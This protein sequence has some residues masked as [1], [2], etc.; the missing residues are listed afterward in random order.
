MAIPNLKPVPGPFIAPPEP[1][2][3]ELAFVDFAA[4]APVDPF[5]TVPDWTEGRQA[6]AQ[7]KIADNVWIAKTANGLHSIWANIAALDLGGESR[8]YCAIEDMQCPVGGVNAAPIALMMSGVYDN[9]FFWG[10]DNDTGG[11]IL[12]Y[13][14]T[15]N[16]D[17]LAVHAYRDVTFQPPYASNNFGNPL[18]G[19]GGTLGRVEMR[20]TIG[21]LDNTIQV[22]VDGLQL[23][24]DWVDGHVD[25]V[26]NLR[27]CGASLKADAAVAS[28]MVRLSSGIFTV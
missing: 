14:L 26:Q 5:S 13:L 25:R 6:G 9:G 27:T 1:P 28:S 18:G 10:S 21:A 3:T 2:E 7:S 15:L 24:G 8:V 11:D 19:A 4:L 23:G 17:L 20:V 16:A 22:L 12:G